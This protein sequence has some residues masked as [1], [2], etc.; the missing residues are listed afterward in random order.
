[1]VS[2]TSVAENVGLE[3][4]WKKEKNKEKKKERKKEKRKKE[5]LGK[6]KIV[7]FLIL[8]W[9]NVTSYGDIPKIL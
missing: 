4:E 6:T 8:K 3:E 5:G 7:R 9:L 1:M 2:I